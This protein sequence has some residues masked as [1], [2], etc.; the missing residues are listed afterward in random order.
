VL[1]AAASFMQQGLDVALP[2]EFASCAD[3]I[4][5]SYGRKIHRYFRCSN[6][7]SD[8]YARKLAENQMFLRDGAVL[9]LNVFEYLTRNNMTLENA[10]KAIPQFVCER[11]EVEINC[12]PQRIISM[13]CA[14]TACGKGEGI[15]IG[16]N[17]ENILIRSSKRGDSLFL[18]A[19]SLSAETA[20]E[21]CDSTEKLIKTLDNEEKM[22]YNQL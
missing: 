17:R 14:S 19:E 4:A 11:R 13:I 3:L 1:I 9:A 12:P 6:D 22:G 18:L 21:L 5:E 7:S 8:A 20:A 16:D 10:V 2:H 15:L